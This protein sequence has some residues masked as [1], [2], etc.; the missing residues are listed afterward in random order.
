MEKFK[1]ELCKFKSSEPFA[2]IE[3]EARDIDSAEE[4]V[5]RFYPDTNFNV[6][7]VGTPA[8]SCNHQWFRTEKMAVGQYRCI[9]CG[10]WEHG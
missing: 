8:L 7:Q 3:I 10:K 9:Y 1:I 4:F 2:C 5:S 6:K